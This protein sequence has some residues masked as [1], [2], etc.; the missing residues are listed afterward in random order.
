VVFVFF[1]SYHTSVKFPP[2]PVTRNTDQ[3]MRPCVASTSAPTRPRPA[4]TATTHTSRTST[5]APR[6][7]PRPLRPRPPS[8]EPRRGWPPRRDARAPRRA[9]RAQGARP[10]A[11]SERAGVELRDQ[12]AH[13]PQRPQTRWRRSGTCFGRVLRPMATLWPRSCPRA[14]LSASFTGDAVL[15]M[16]RKIG[17]ATD[18][19]VMSG[20]VN[21]Y[22]TFKSAENARK[23]LKKCLRGMLCPGRP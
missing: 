19:F 23:V 22:G 9:L 18:L 3:P 8:F 10:N 11:T 7:A 17:Y 4:L 2:N 21:F 16:V 20:L 15:A 5:H 1:S 13:R 12:R 14:P 6:G